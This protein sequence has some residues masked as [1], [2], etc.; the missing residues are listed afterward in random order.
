MKSIY[1]FYLV[2]AFISFYF[3]FGDILWMISEKKMTGVELLMT[4]D[5]LETETHD[6]NKDDQP[7]RKLNSNA[8][9]NTAT[10]LVLDWVRDIQD[11]VQIFFVSISRRSDNKKTHVSSHCPEHFLSP[12][13]APDSLSIYLKIKF[14]YENIL[15]YLGAFSWYIDVVSKGLIHFSLVH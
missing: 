5:N 14:I 9:I 6:H 1:P 4:H 3:L 13:L 2:C 12:A 8:K 10:H 7:N 15:L 11:V